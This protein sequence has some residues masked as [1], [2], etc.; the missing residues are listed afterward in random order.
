M[1]S[2]RAF[3]LGCGFLAAAVIAC[4]RDDRG[5]TGDE[6]GVSQQIG[7]LLAVHRLHQAG[8]SIET[9]VGPDGWQ[10]ISTSARSASQAIGLDVPN[11]LEPP[12]SV[13][14]VV[15][16][17]RWDWGVSPPPGSVTAFFVVEDGEVLGAWLAVEQMEGSV[18]PLNSLEVIRIGKPSEGT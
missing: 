7:T 13:R 10:Y 8:D 18:K 15:L 17:E 9:T 1:S 12:L 3:A 4:D 16:E 11:D 14:T 2:R 5:D 6:A